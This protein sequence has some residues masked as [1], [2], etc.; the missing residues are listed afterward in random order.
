[1]SRSASSSDQAQDDTLAFAV[2]DA[3]AVPRRHVVEDYN[4]ESCHTNLSLHGENRNNPQY[5]VTCHRP[6]AD[7]SSQRAAGDTPQSIHFKYMIHKIHRGENLASGLYRGR[8]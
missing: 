1:M 4:C 6:D 5:C 3:T 8:L 2:T 7:D